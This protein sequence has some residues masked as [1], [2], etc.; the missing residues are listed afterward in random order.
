[1]AITTVSGIASNLVETTLFSKQIDVPGGLNRH[2]STIYAPGI[3]APATAPSPGAAGAALTSY[4]GQIPI[5]AASANTYLAGIR[6]CSS[7]HRGHLLL[8][9]RLWH[10]SGLSVVSTVSQTV[11]SVAWPARDNNQSTNGEGVLI[12]CEVS[13]LT[14]TNAPTLSMTYTN[15]DGTASRTS[16]NIIGTSSASRAGFFSVMGLQAGD[17]G[18]R[19]VQN[20]TLSASWVSGAFHLVAF[21]ILATVEVSDIGLMRQADALT[22]NFVRLYDNTVPFVLWMPE[23]VVMTYASASIDFAQG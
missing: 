3:P 17:K 1:M 19:S 7:T 9:D 18:V 15:S 6:V 5:P 14:S 10:N 13:S 23:N 21:R 2:F 20:F 11:N 4:A 16:T 8:C 22:S 12:G